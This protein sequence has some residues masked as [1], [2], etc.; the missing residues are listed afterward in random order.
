MP[1]DKKEQKRL[2]DIEYRRKNKSSLAAKKK[3]AYERD[4]EKNLAKFKAYRAR[5]ETVARHNKYCMQPE[6]VEKKRVWDVVYRTMKIYG[7]FWESAILVNQIEI[8][9][10]KLIPRNE[11]LSTKRCVKANTE[12]NC[13][14]RL[15]KAISK[16]ISGEANRGILS[17]CWLDESREILESLILD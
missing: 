7:E 16:I 8:E 13:K 12:R 11:R 9:V 3:A 2:Y 4:R 17:S 1:K 10:R 5:P 14:R 6:Y 15:D